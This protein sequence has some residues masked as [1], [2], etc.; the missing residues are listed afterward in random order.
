MEIED[1]LKVIIAEARKLAIEWKHGFI[2]YDHFFV[3]MLKNKCIASYYLD[4]CDAKDWETK[5]KELYPNNSKLTFKDSLAL[6]KEAERVI[7]H[8]HKIAQHISNKGSTNT[9]HV[10]LAMLSYNN[11]VTKSFNKA[12]ILI[13]DITESH[14]K[15]RYKTFPPI[16]KPIRRK[17][18]NKVQIFFFSLSSKLKKID[19]LYQN[20]LNLFYY[21]QFG[22][23]IK[24]C[25]V[26]LSLSPSN[27]DFKFLLAYN[28][29]NQIDYESSLILIKELVKNNPENAHFLLSLSYIND[30]IGN[31]ST[32][33][34]IIDA[35]LLLQPDNDVYLNNKGFNLVRQTK[36]VES[37]SFFEQSIQKNPVF[38]YPWNNLGFAKYKLGET[39][40]AISNIDKSI[41][42]DKSNAY[43]Y[44]NKGIIY[45][46]LGNKEEALKNFNLSLKFG[47]SEKYDNE[48]L[49]LLEQLCPP[50]GGF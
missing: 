31:Y 41:E 35:L 11:D 39:D 42:L 34:E 37:I 17:V 28:F 4:H 49:Q 13:E 25:Q 2:N 47:Y 19:E 27:L 9:I 5:I 24:T 33:A 36:Y 46:E 32:A 14:F 12:A 8:S 38:S 29:I 48:V 10:I 6:T 18:Y 16:I 44:K 23:S 7:N 21:Q 50:P 40:N 1:D 22:D 45:F 26:G 15:K 3:S 20:A 43:A 30:M